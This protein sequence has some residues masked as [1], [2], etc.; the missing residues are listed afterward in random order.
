M[1]LITSDLN[2]D[3][4]EIEN[5]HRLAWQKL[6]EDG[7]NYEIKGSSGRVKL[8][9]EEIYKYKRELL[10]GKPAALRLA[11]RN[12]ERVKST[13]PA[14]DYERYNIRSKLQSIFNYS[15]LIESYLPH[16]GAYKLV[17]QLNV[18][19]CVYCNRIFSFTLDKVDLARTFN[20]TKDKKVKRKILK[21]ISSSKTRPELDHFYPK[22]KFPYLALAL[23]NLVPS[24]HICNSSLKGSRN[25]DFDT[26]INPYEDDFDQIMKIKVKF[27]KE[28]EIQKDID[29]GKLAG[30]V[31]DHF[32]YLLF[33]GK[34]ESFDL[35]F[36]RVNAAD[37]IDN[38]KARNHIEL[39]ALNELYDIHKDH[40]TRILKNAIRH[41]SG[42]ARD[43]FARHGNLFHSE[44]ETRSALLGTESNPDK[45]N[46]FPLSKLAIDICSD[47]GI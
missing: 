26:L 3:F 17:Q 31:K 9:Y 33:V 2:I 6:V 10:I 13:L 28:A 22:A 24:C 20:K 1:K 29:S 41:G 45:I 46:Q 16:W 39:Y 40:A 4:V 32:G 8:L 43:I 21:D 23:Y 30:Q 25:V 36:E 38:T 42:S 15:G 44:E 12:I 7:L 34:L 19:S 37:S 35:K 18:N 11:R 14:G 47:F 5:Q 27:R